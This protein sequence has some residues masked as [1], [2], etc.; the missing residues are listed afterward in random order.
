MLLRPFRTKEKR[1]LG[2]LILVLFIAGIYLYLNYLEK[3]YSPDQAV[4]AE[5]YLKAGNYEQAVEAYQKV[6]LMKDIDRQ[7]ISIGLADAYVGMEKFDKALE[8]LRACYQ[9]T[10]GSRVKDKIEEV[11]AE[12]IDY[13]YQQAASRA[14]VYYSREEYDKA[15]GEYEKAKKIK[16]K[17]P[18][19]Y[20]RITQAYIE[21]GEYELAREEV[22]EGQELTQDAIF[23]DLLELVDSYLIK[24]NYTA[25]I[26][27]GAEY[28]TQE[29]YDAGIAAYKKAAKL[30]PKESAAYLELAKVY[31]S[32]KEYE[33]AKTLLSAAVELTNNEELAKLLE[34]VT[35]QE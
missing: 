3:K 24:D 32:Q 8:V 16:S 33:K 1:I 31:L 28:I 34:E 5:N 22:L 6:L 29:N 30:L 25:L 18:T 12:K 10:A 14:E 15:I 27:Q 21:K 35:E 17:E 13:D 20:I 19:S 4:M 26:K 2:F 9:E 23:I 7:H 11:T